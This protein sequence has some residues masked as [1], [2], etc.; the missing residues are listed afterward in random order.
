MSLLRL[1]TDCWPHWGP[2]PLVS[3]D[4]LPYLSY[5]K[6]VE[7]PWAAAD[8]PVIELDRSQ[9]PARHLSHHS[10]FTAEVESKAMRDS[11]WDESQTARRVEKNEGQTLT[12]E[13]QTWIA[14][15]SSHQPPVL[16]SSGISV[17]EAAVSQPMGQTNDLL[18]SDVVEIEGLVPE[19]STPQQADTTGS[20][21]DDIWLHLARE[22]QQFATDGL[23]SD[24]VISVVSG[25]LPQDPDSE[26]FPHYDEVLA[27]EWERSTPYF[28]NQSI[29]Q[30][31]SP[32]AVPTQTF[33]VA[34]QDFARSEPHYRHPTTASKARCL[35]SVSSGTA[36]K[37]SGAPSSG[38]SPVLM[39]SSAEMKPVLAVETRGRR[40]RAV[41]EQMIVDNKTLQILSA[42]V[43]T[44]PPNASAYL[45]RPLPPIPCQRSKS[46]RYPRTAD[47]C[48]LRV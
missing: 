13:L 17:V 21:E 44:L 6:P 26:A 38:R 22:D 39:P 20:S 42:P 7:G 16:T 37:V 48:R 12:S 23:E 5:S 4:T 29:C 35:P 25:A 47:S 2:I 36:H 19:I 34:V 27:Q 8:T 41:G 9:T 43:S 28:E 33:S 32:L 3:G 30:F 31:S 24:D 40:C 46:D 11:W 45:N 15:L 10:I 14:R 1:R 18:A